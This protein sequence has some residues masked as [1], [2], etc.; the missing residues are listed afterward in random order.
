MTKLDRLL[1]VASK[2]CEKPI[3]GASETSIIKNH[4]DKENPSVMQLIQLL[5]N[6]DRLRE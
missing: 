1:E 4:G 5:S 6:G 2:D 3:F